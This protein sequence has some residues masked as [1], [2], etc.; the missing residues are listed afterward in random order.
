L[1]KLNIMTNCLILTIKVEGGE[2][3]IYVSP[4]MLQSKEPPDIKSGPIGRLY[5]YDPLRDDHYREN[6]KK[7]PID[8]RFKSNSYIINYGQDFEKFYLG[9]LWVDFDTKRHWQ[10]EGNSSRLCEQEVNAL[11]KLLFNSYSETRNVT[12]FTPTRPSDI[13]LSRM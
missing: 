9:S 2:R 11:G 6:L 3:E 10:W 4:V 5:F 8:E 13:N 1:Q 7:D 12:I